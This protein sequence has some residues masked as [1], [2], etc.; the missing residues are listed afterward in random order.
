LEAVILSSIRVIPTGAF[1]AVAFIVL[2][3]LTSPRISAQTPSLSKEYIRLNGQVIAIENTA[4]AAPAAPNAS[5]SPTSLT[6]PSQI[7][8]TT[9]TTQTVTLSNSGTAALSI[10]SIG[11]TG[12]NASNFATT[13]NCGTSLAASA[14]CAISVTFNPVTAGTLNATLTATDNSGNNPGSQQTVSL[15]GSAPAPTPPTGA[16]YSL[17]TDGSSTE[18]VNLPD[19][20]PFNNLQSWRL[21]TRIHGITANSNGFDQLF[22]RI[23][24]YDITYWL[25][26]TPDGSTLILGNSAENTTN[27]PTNQFYCSAALNGA[28]DVQIRFQRNWATQAY[29]L[30]VWNTATG[31]PLTVSGNCGSILQ[32]TVSLAG[33]LMLGQNYAGGIAF[34]RVYTSALTS[35]TPPSNFRPGGELLDYE[36]EN[37]ASLGEEDSGNNQTLS[38][39][40]N[41][42]QVPTPGAGATPTPPTVSFTAPTNGASVS[43]TISITTAPA[44]TTSGG[45]VASVQLQVDG[46]SLGSAITSSPYSTSWGTTTVANGT[47][48]VTAIVTDTF[49]ETA[50]SSVT[51]T[52]NN[53]GAPTGGLY[54]LHLDGASEEDTNLPDAAPFNNLSSF[55]VETRIHGITASPSGLTQFFSM[56]SSYDLSLTPDGSTLNLAN[57]GENQP[58][59]ETNQ[60]YCSAP[61]NGATDIQVRFQRNGTLQSYQLQVWNTATGHLLA[62]SGNCG[63]VLQPTVSLAGSSVVGRFYKGGMAF[64]RLYNTAVTS[65]T[66]PSNFRPGGELL[67]YEFENAASLGEEGSGNDLMFSPSGNP[68]QV[69]TPGAGGTPTPPTISFTAPTNGAVVSGTISIATAPATTTS[70]A[71]VASV[72]L[73]VDGASLGAAITNSPYSTSWGTTTVANGTHTL[74]AIVTDTFGETARAS[75]TVTVNNAGA[76][77]GGVYSLYLDGASEED[78]DLPDD[79]PFNNLSSFRVETRIHGITASPSGLTQQFWMTAPWYVTYALTLSP[80]GSTLGLANIGENPEDV[81]T[82]QFYCNVALNGA[83]DIQ[84]R[85][86]RNWDMGIYQLQVWNTA[87]GQPL[88]DT[89]TCGT[90]LQPTVSLAGSFVVGRFFRGGMAYLRIYNS[91]V[92]SS[93]PPSNLRPGGELLDY[94]F[95]N[96]ASLGEEG[97]GNDQTLSPSGNPTQVQTPPGGNN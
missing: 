12:A 82:N 52:V 8:G 38:P 5:L 39:S 27:V 4:P 89:G 21:E 18:S 25:G 37:A 42:T 53:A 65:S 64:L 19:A 44:A 3:A 40:G 46:A 41:P 28:T 33:Q 11:I 30:Q 77:T 83:T 29:Q 91:A 61:L 17:Y 60:F 2:A 73:Q 10:T 94:E 59:Q 22:W 79:A 88:V 13:N 80:D 45:S 90:V 93:T 24:P 67:D 1:T 84:I 69:P 31:Q 50:R 95:E 70:G 20:A 68:T 6:F 55:R 51:V 48:T 66:P 32:P 57:V 63:T 47:H 43:G 16:A 23:A 71:S 49:G 34:M 92:T 76:P 56:T 36:F 74:T 26:L 62:D 58:G 87:T 7:I 81:G 97:S 54:S 96:A 72:Q 9:P 85:F 14:T 35:S 78:A 15:S 75:V 86:Q